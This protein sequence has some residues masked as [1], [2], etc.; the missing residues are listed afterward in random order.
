MLLVCFF[1]VVWVTWA[2]TDLALVTTSLKTE[3]PPKTPR[4]RDNSK[5]PTTPRHRV[6]VVGKPM[7]PRSKLL[8]TPTHASTP[9]TVIT[10][11]KSLFSRGTQGG[12]LIG[13]DTERL[14]LNAFI[15]GC[16]ASKSGGCLYI[17]GPPGCGKSALLTELMGELA[18]DEMHTIKKAW[19]NCMSLH[20]PNSIYGSLL[21]SF[22]PT[23]S[24]G[25]N[26]TAEFP[27]LEKLLISTNTKTTYVL[28]LD[29]ID[30]LLAN[31]VLPK[32]FELSLRKNSRL[33]LIGIANALD[34]TDRF[35]P[36]L[37]AKGLEPHLIPFLSYT[38]PQISE[39]LT[40]RLRS[41]LTPAETEECD[42]GFLPFVHPAAIQLLSRKVASASG[43][44]RKAFDILRRSLE[45][46]EQESLQAMRAQNA[47]FDTEN[48][49]IPG[50]GKGLVASPPS[51]RLALAETT[52]NTTASAR[53][54]K[55]TWTAVTVPRATLAHVA[56]ASSS[57]LGAS[58]SSR[59]VT[60]NA[61]QKSLLCVL[62][63]RAGTSPYSLQKLRDAYA[64]ACKNRDGEGVAMMPL[65]GAE[66]RAVIEGLEVA[67]VVDI[68]DGTSS[69]TSGTPKKKKIMNAGEGDEKITARIGKMELLTALSAPGVVG[70]DLFIRIL[71]S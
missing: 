19:V 28:V 10:T 3:N 68:V 4:H 57:S 70:R 30:Y 13:R 65:V 8:N 71:G 51:S 26:K 45:L 27:H 38:A 52:L 33:I 16:L 15:Q 17:S 23:L 9:T 24:T 25:K 14:Q 11:A 39:V 58:V 29:E 44:L 1:L 64:A 20:T 49:K 41:L 2:V 47:S 66:F 69:G 5:K 67:G 37:K 55:I 32:L 7:T 53:P 42:P 43:D 31:D 35:L 48:T 56:K 60:L 36:R 63:A 21:D 61:H 46:V 62:V 54:A 50:S 59:I 12:R 40:S 18:G 6:S 34:L 22:S